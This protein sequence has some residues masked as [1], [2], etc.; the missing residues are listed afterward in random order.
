M[1]S[2]RRARSIE[3]NH[4]RDR[5]DHHRIMKMQESIPLSSYFQY[6]YDPAKPKHDENHSKL[7]LKE[8][9]EEI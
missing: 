2:S 6:F 9:M 7:I 5:D 3:T 1:R 4:A 8:R